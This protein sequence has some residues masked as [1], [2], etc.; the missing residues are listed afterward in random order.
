[1]CKAQLRNTDLAARYGGEE[2]ALLLPETDSAAAIQVVERLCQVL[3]ETDIA[4]GQEITTRVTV[5][6][7][8]AMFD[9]TTD[10]F[11]ALIQRADQALYRAKHS[12]RNRV[13]LW[14]GDAQ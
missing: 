3:A 4:L 5:S 13:I 7:G 6:A 10:S 14:T 2:F 1:M 11:D 12:G 8:I 9:A